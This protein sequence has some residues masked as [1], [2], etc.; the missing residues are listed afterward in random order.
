M[1]IA[2]LSTRAAMAAFAFTV[3]IASVADAQAWNYPAFQ[4]PRVVPRE[5]NFA[6]ADGGDVAGSSFIFQWRQGRTGNTQL[7]LD[8][9]FAD[10]EF[11]EE[12]FLLGAQFAKQLMVAR[13]DMPFDMLLTLGMNGAFGGDP[14]PLLFVPV[15]VSMGHRFRLEGP[16]AITPFAHPRLSLDYCGDCVDETELG[17]AFDIGASFELN[18]N[19]ALR[20]AA[21]LGGSDDSIRGEDAIGFSL[22]W[23]PAIVRRR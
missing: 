5:F 8:A 7:S 3:G 15:G 13:Q 14:G 23:S 21:T 2:R 10:T 18:P 11:D 6:V 22:A 20:I 17:V 1:S 12:F 16:M 9:G 4:Q 19:I